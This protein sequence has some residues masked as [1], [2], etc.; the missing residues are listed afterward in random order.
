[1]MEKE[2]PVAVEAVA[3]AGPVRSSQS[4]PELAPA[5]DVIEVAPTFLRG[6]V[7]ADGTELMPKW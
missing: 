2:A 1:M 6:G 7:A 4:Q 5:A 3:V